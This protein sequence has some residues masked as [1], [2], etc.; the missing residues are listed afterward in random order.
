MKLEINGIKKTT[1]AQQTVEELLAI[2]K[3]KMPDMVTVQV[4]GEIVDRARY[5]GHDLADGDK[6]DFLYFMGGGGGDRG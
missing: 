6:V 2:E 5:A 1:Q 3:V 4:N